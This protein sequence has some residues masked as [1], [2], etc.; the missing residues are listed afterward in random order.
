MSTV[1]S[2]MVTMITVIMGSPISGLSI[3]RS[4]SRPR[5]T[6]KAMVIKKAHTK[7][8]CISTTTQ[9]QM[10]APMRTNS[11]WAK[12]ITLVALYISTNPRATRA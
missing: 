4:T 2:P 8:I 10:Y 1:A 11:P 12:L 7:G 3:N 6:E 9:R 5:T